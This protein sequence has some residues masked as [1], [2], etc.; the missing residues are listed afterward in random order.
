MQSHDDRGV[1]ALIVLPPCLWSILTDYHLI[2]WWSCSKLATLA[3]GNWT[4]TVEE[5]NN[6]GKKK[7]LISSRIVRIKFT[8]PCSVWHD[9]TK[10]VVSSLI[11]VRFSKFKIWHTQESKADLFKVRNPSR[12]RSHHARAISRAR[13]HKSE[14]FKSVDQV[15]SLYVTSNQSD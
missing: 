9:F 3:L 1:S 4:K 13:R 10:M 14:M 11:L 6:T 7:C 8:N 5:L 12:A 15:L 2:V